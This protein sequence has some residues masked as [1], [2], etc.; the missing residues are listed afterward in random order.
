MLGQYCVGCHSGTAPR[1]GFDLDALGDTLTDGVA[2]HA[3]SWEKVVR[4][5][6]GGM[7]PPM[8]AARPANAEIDGFVAWLET[9]LDA[10]LQAEPD[11]GRAPIHRLNRTEYGNAIRD[12]LD[13]EVDAAQF[14]P[15]D[16]ESHGFDNIADAL[17]ISPSLL[18]QYLAASRKVAALAVGDPET[19]VLSQVFRVPPDRVQEEHIEGLPLGTR[20]GT[21][22][23]HNFPLD[24]EY[25]FSV[26]LMRNIVGY[27]KGL[28]WP[29]ELEITI[30]GERTF[31]APVGGDE[32][33]AMSDANFAAAADAID[34]RLKTR[35]PVT[36][37]P[38][39]V[40]IAFLR[41]NS[42]ESHEPLEPHT[43]DHDLQNMN[44]IPL[45]DYV[46]I[47]G[48]LGASGPGDTPSRR[49]IFSCYP[50]YP[51]GA[52]E[53]AVC[54]REILGTLARRAYR[55]PVSA[56]ELDLVLDFYEEGRSRGTF[57]AGIQGGLQF[58]LA[59]P[60]FIFRSEPDPEGIEP[61]DVYPLADL[62]LA[63][64]LSFFLWSTLPDDELLELAV[65][66]ALGNPDVLERQV[67]RMLADPRSEDLVSNFAGQWLLLRNLRS[68][69]PDTLL[70]PNFDDNLRQAFR[71][72]TELLLDSIIREDRSVLD[73]LT[74]DY[75]FVNERLAAHYGIP[76]VYGSHFRR[77]AVTDEM[78]RGLLGHGSILTVTSYPNRTSPVLRGKFVL[79]NLM[80]TPPPAPPPDVPDLEENEPGRAARSLRERLEDHRANPACASCHAVMDPLGLALENFDAIGRFRTREPGGVVDAAGQ[81]ADG[82]AVEGPSTLRDALVSDPDRFVGTMT[83]KLLTYALGRGLGYSDMPVI[84]S[85]VGRAEDDEYRMSSIV[86]GIVEST[87]FRMKRSGAER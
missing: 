69:T 13:L 12:L 49:R 20:G 17:T 47:T 81:L 85:I 58:V 77:V 64:R 8:G 83:E 57:E 29:H 22:I 27:M 59:S 28:E 67:R 71:R 44:G 87:P 2:D 72:E 37:G 84:R 38:H 15:P 45:I 62:A 65:E 56:G 51:S 68:A 76:N 66:G 21:R 54:A 4:K 18:E 16:T 40:G 35:I 32:D 10:A 52:S 48:P 63:S 3:E 75:T 60:N 50:S 53:E 36:A 14:L 46:A 41:R 30:D 31:L 79:E 39:E 33:N 23:R 73:M 9:S 70:F 19:A 80:G 6:R 26:F 25:Q 5:L 11:P 78:R 86:M 34:E 55:R 61:G 74:A 43:R 7:M 42:A 1:A 24:A 82:T